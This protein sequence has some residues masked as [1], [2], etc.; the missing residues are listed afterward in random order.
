MSLG[1]IQTEAP[2]TKHEVLP[3]GCT[4]SV[5]T[6]INAVP[7]PFRENVLLRAGVTSVLLY[8]GCPFI[9]SGESILRNDIW[10]IIQESSS[11]ELAE[12]SFNTLFG[13]TRFESLLQDFCG[14]EKIP[15]IDAIEEYIEGCLL[16]HCLKLCLYG[17][18]A[19][20]QITRG[21]KGE[22]ET[23]D[24]TSSYPEPSGN[25]Q[26]PLPD[27]CLP[28]VQQSIEAV[29]M[30]SAIIRRIQLMRCILNISSGQIEVHNLREILH[31]QAV[32]KSMD[33]LPIW[34]C[35]W[36]HDTALL[37]HAGTRGLFSILKDVGSESGS[38]A[39]PIFSREAI[40]QHIKNTFFARAERIP[41]PITEASSPDDT[42][43]WIDSYANEFPTL[44][45]I[46]R[47]LAFL[48]SEA[49]ADLDD[50]NRFYNLPMH[51]HGGWPRN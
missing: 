23:S 18:S 31:S 1:N 48:C 34:W 41:G 8:F 13:A 29:G 37:A 33:G 36:I 49:T 43:D 15:K 6:P 50:K 9:G 11:I 45:V 28:L 47:R 19:T 22:Y 14:H 30:A 26:S 17:N 38:N 25:L 40:K 24:G 5:I 46:E 2:E 32:R 10:K 51:D 42:T 44:N 21:S 20:T 4:M 12:N 27:P 3:E 16:P 35:P 7:M 39:G